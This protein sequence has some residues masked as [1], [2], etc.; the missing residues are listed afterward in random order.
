M[1]SNWQERKT[2]HLNK[3]IQRITEKLPSDSAQRA[4]AF[5]RQYYQWV[6]QDDLMERTTLDLYGAALSH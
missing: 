2:E 1:S 3:V 4:I 6:A 5:T